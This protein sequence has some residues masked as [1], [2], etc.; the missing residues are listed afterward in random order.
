MYR[1]RQKAEDPNLKGLP[2]PHHT[3]A[4]SSFLGQE[5]NSAY[6]QKL[7][8]AQWLKPALGLGSALKPAVGCL[9]DKIATLK[10]AV[11][12]PMGQ[13]FSTRNVQ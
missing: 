10:L 6:L 13:S 5:P 7:V 2:D 3:L 11:C 12:I 4:S 1:Q 8:L 9:R